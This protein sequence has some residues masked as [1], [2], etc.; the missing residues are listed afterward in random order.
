MILLKCV[1]LESFII[2]IFA[3]F[4]LCSAERQEREREEEKKYE[5]WAIENDFYNESETKSII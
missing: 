2:M 4:C 1:A 5:I 3:P